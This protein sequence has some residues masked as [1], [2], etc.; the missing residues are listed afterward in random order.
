M[1]PKISWEG[2]LSGFFVGFLFALIFNEKTI[3]NKKYD[4]ER[5]DFNPEEDPFISQFDEEGNF[6]ETPK[7]EPSDDLVEINSSKEKPLIKKVI[8]TLKKTEPKDEKF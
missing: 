7:E 4:W 1:D 6:I 3:Q 5:D 2:H 8:Y